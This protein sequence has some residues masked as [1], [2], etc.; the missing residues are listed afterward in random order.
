M[1]VNRRENLMRRV[2]VTALVFTAVCGLAVANG[3]IRDRVEHRYADSN[4]VKIHYATLGEGPLIVFIHGFPDFWWSWHHQMDGLKGNFRVA[5]MDTR[6]YNKSDKPKGV[7]NYDMSLL[8]GDVAAVI[9]D[10]GE[11]K[12]IIVGHDWGGA[13]AWN[14]AMYM[15]QMTDKLMIV[16]LPH[17][18]GI[19]RELAKKEVQYNNAAYARNF[20]KPDSHKAFT[21]AGLASMLAK[22]DEQKR[23]IYE[24]A[25]SN[26]DFDAM[27]NYYRRN[28]PREE[29]AANPQELPRI[30]MPVLEFHGLKDQALYHHC[31]G[32]TW[33]EMDQDFT[34][35]TIPSVGHWAH[36]EAADLVT[37]T[38]KWWLLSRQ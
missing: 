24:E 2:L 25:F 4:G 9:K 26:S 8:I 27:M 3:D 13:I 30:T 37:T 22:G 29:D 36:H 15:P 7:E 11:E 14:F 32:N 16:N 5:A 21:A 20:Q 17:P 10:A 19:A 18:A 31:L 6:G 34:L 1:Q 33:E 35:V 23:A 12:A 38:M 28:Y